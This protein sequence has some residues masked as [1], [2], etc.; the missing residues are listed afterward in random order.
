MRFQIS[1]LRWL[2][3]GFLLLALGLVFGQTVRRAFV[4]V[5][6]NVYIYENPHISRGLTVPGFVYL[7]VGWFWYVGMLLPVIGLVQFGLQSVANSTRQSH[8]IG[9]RWPFGPTSRRS[10]TAWGSPWRLLASVTR[11]WPITGGPW[12][13]GPTSPRLATT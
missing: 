3:C 12:K 1:D 4:N 7:L 8:S 10:T 2:C 9:R 13:S 5:D 11:R 6:D